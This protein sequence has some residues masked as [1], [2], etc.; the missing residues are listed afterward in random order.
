MDITIM[1]VSIM[2]PRNHHSS[3]DGSDLINT[4]F[5]RES[6]HLLKKMWKRVGAWLTPLTGQP[7]VAG[8][9]TVMSVSG[10][11]RYERVDRFNS[12]I[13]GVDSIIDGLVVQTNQFYTVN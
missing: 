10:G 8:D 3:S 12:F 4:P 5:P 2:V 11:D 9:I 7:M 1:S 6:P 13:N